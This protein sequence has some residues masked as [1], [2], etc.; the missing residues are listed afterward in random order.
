MTIEDFEKTILQLVNIFQ[1]DTGLNVN[2]IYFDESE[3]ENNTDKS[4]VTVAA[5]IS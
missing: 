1:K 3:E 5:E 2:G 4:K